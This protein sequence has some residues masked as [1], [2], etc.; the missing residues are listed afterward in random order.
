MLRSL[1]GIKGYQLSAKDGE[2]GHIVNFYFDD[3]K[4]TIKFLVADTGTWLPGRNVLLSS[5]G[6]YGKP[7]WA[8]KTFPVVFPSKDMIQ[9][10]PDE[11]SKKTVSDYKKE[12]LY[13]FTHWPEWA[14]K[15]PHDAPII[16][17]AKEIENGLARIEEKIKT[18]LRSANEIE[19]YHIQT[20]DKEMGHVTDFIIDDE[21]WT[22]RFI[23]V[24]TKNLLPGKEV[25]LVPLWID[26][27]RWSE[28]KIFVDLTEEELKNSPIY[29]PSAAI[30]QKQE[31]ILFD[32]YGRPKGRV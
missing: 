28:K 9:E 3:A 21:D 23:V 6:F 15:H 22:I 7:D 31:K 25:M 1:N 8:T 29:N 17:Y 30:N 26:R 5:A 19:G 20:L 18:H 2:I 14:E 11:E 32:Y 13:Y 10:C 4:W 16:G 24:S 27:I 12:N